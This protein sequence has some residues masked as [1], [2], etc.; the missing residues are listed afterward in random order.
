M[1]LDP[2]SVVTD[3]TTAVMAGPELVGVRAT[4]TSLGPIVPAGKPLPVTLTN[5][6]P[7]S[8]AA[9]VAA[10]VNATGA[11]VA[12]CTVVIPCTMMSAPPEKIRLR[13]STSANR[14]VSTADVRRRDLMGG[15]APQFLGIAWLPST[16]A[17]KTAAHPFELI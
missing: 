17:E 13:R 9:G 12:A 8:A 6:T 10:D 5:V 2:K 7:G 14:R 4:V 16:D 1:R 3:C 11:G 15:V